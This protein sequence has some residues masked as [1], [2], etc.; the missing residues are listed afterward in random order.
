M[1]GKDNN[2]TQPISQASSLAISAIELAGEIGWQ[3]LTMQDLSE[4]SGFGL[5]EIR[6]LIDDKGDLLVLFGKVIDKKVLAIHVASDASMPPR[7]KL[8]DILMDRFDT[9]NEHRQGILAVLESFK[10]DPK[11]LLISC[12]HLCKSMCWMLGAAG[13]ETNGIRGALRVAGLTGLYIK[14]LKVWKNDESE[15]MAKVMAALDKDLG[16]LE[17]AEISLGL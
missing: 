5:G 2:K 17:Q 11:Q 8:F 7:D 3:Q 4:K 6:D 10:Y 16:R 1:S 12:P 9:L 14:T 15:D 13:I